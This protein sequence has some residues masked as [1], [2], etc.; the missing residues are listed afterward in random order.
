MKVLI[1]GDRNWNDL[2]SIGGVLRRLVKRYTVQEL[3]IIEGEA[4][5]ADRMARTEAEDLGIKVHRFPADWSKYHKAA[6]P[7]RNS[8]MLAE[9]PDMVIAFHNN[10]L[11]SKGTQDMLTKSIKAGKDCYIFTH[12]GGLRR[13][14]RTE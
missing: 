9:G 3:E 4:R 6:G 13:Y 5:G 14:L 8:K 12:E 2:P 10:I 1:C 11:E 7:I